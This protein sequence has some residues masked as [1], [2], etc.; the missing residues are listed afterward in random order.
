MTTISSLG[1]FSCL[2]AFPRIISD[3]PLEIW[4]GPAFRS[5]PMRGNCGVLYIGGVKS[6]DTGFIP[7]RAEMRTE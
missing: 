5:L 4:N 3:R 1:R 7:K 2:M 6:L